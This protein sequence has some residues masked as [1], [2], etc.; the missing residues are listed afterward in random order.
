MVGDVLFSTSPIPAEDRAL[1]RELD[2][3]GPFQL[4]VIGA[5]DS[6]F[7]QVLSQLRLGAKI[8]VV[9]RLSDLSTGG[10][11]TTL[12]RL[13]SVRAAGGLVVD[14]LSGILESQAHTETVI[15]VLRWVKDSEFVRQSVARSAG[16]RRAAPSVP[17]PV[18]IP[19]PL[20]LDLEA[21]CSCGHPSRFHE[22]GSGVC[23]KC[24]DPTTD[25]FRCPR[26]ERAVPPAT[27]P[28]AGGAQP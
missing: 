10:Y 23:W 28:V 13:V 5:G 17:G 19:Q 4:E 25:E 12:D 27:G 2:L 14:G 9:P 20:S 22:K 16:R 8:V 3:D 15:T 18:S 1:L 26:F 24:L 11:R 21:L 7:E 6:E